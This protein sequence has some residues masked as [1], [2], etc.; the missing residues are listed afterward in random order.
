MKK[1]LDLP[2]EVARGFIAAMS[3]YFTEEDPHK[4]DAIAHQLD[5]LRQYQGTR[6]K[7]LRLSDVQ[8]MFE[9]MRPL[10]E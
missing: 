10:I 8:G 2:P 4:R 9:A 5:V 6:E 7:K 1:P 3:D